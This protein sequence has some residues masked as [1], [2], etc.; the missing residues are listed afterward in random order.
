MTYCSAVLI[1]TWLQPGGK[2]RVAIELFQRL[3]VES[4]TLETVYRS[5]SWMH[6][7]KAGC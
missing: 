1:N 3:T 2:T 5:C 7:A 4:K 6:L